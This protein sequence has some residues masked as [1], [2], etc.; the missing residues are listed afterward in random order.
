MDK[1]KE[2]ERGISHDSVPQQ[3]CRFAD[4]LIDPEA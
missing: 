4:P 2:M 3:G 1:S